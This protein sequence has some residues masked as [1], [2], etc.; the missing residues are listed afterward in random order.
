M[1][2][3][4]ILCIYC[5]VPFLDSSFT[6]VTFFLIRVVR[7]FASFIVDIPPRLNPLIYLFLLFFCF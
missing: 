6:F 2:Y 5:C 3:L 1:W 4:F 7:S